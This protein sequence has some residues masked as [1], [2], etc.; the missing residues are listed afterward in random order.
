MELLTG[1]RE[2]I[3]FVTSNLVLFYDDTQSALDRGCYDCY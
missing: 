2:V 3:L 1:L